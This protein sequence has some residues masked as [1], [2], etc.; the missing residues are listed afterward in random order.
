MLLPT[1]QSSATATTSLVGSIL[2]DIEKRQAEEEEK[3]K[4][5]KDDKI[6]KAQVISDDARKAA[7]EKINAHF[8]D[9][10]RGDA[11][12]NRAVL[13]R[14][15]GEYFGIDRETFNSDAAFARNVENQLKN[16]K[17]DEIAKIEEELGVDKLGMSLGDLVEALK[18]P[19]GRENEM[20]KAA[21]GETGENGA[22][23]Q[24]QAAKAVDRLK[25]ASETGSL[26]EAQVN[27]LRNDPTRSTNKQSLDEQ[28]QQVRALQLKDELE[29]VAD[30]RERQLPLIRIDESGL[31][32]PAAQSL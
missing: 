3:A 32:S 24:A 5:T 20:L 21:L 23:G 12:N 22:Q 28:E 17:A 10:A 2:K 27:S 19:S 8:F 14:A 11:S 26:E 30:R 6:L 29:S 13:I 16:L 15:V 7:N 18:N 9:N 4:G 25:S 1:Q 31:Y